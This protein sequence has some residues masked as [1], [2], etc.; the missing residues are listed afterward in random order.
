MKQNSTSH[1]R[2]VSMA[3]AAV[4]ILALC[5]QVVLAGSAGRT[6]PGSS[7]GGTVPVSGRASYGYGGSSYLFY[8][9]SWYGGYFYD[10]FPW[11]GAYGWY[12]GPWGYHPYRMTALK[13]VPGD[14]TPALLE[15][16]L[17]PKKARLILDGEDL[18]KVKQFNGN[19]DRL[20]LAPGV[21]TLEF[22]ADG[23]RTLR[24]EMEA[25]SGSFY[26]LDYRM[27]KG[28]GEDPRSSR[29][30]SRNERR[31]S[32]GTQGIRTGLI[33]IRVQPG[34]ASV[35]LDG[36]FLGGGRELSRLHGALPVAAGSHRIEIVRPGYKARQ[37]EVEV[38]GEEPLRLDVT[39]ERE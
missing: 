19:W 3:A 24:L 12:G 13:F 7:D 18:G 29:L 34:D 5:S 8:P 28:E 25:E 33:S 27:E 16:D 38:T 4:M 36:E 23:Y 11:Y 22:R 26:R 9:S 10:P 37:L 30:S 20:A 1:T 17:R 39:L 6:R 21:H 15:T 32:E 31:A 35:Y 14:E 2:L